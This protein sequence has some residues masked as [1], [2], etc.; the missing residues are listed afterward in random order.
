MVLI[1]EPAK[2]LVET[3]EKNKKSNEA[4]ADD[5]DYDPNYTSEDLA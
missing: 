3:M 5:D 2:K 1:K 4:A